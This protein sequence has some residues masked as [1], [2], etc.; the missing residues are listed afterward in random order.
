MT[1]QQLFPNTKEKYPSSLFHLANIKLP[2]YFDVLN[3]DWK[4]VEPMIEKE[5]LSKQRLRFAIFPNL[6]HFDFIHFC[7]VYALLIIYRK[8]LKAGEDITL[9]L[10][11]LLS[12]RSMLEKCATFSPGQFRCSGVAFTSEIS[13]A[14]KDR[15][16]QNVLSDLEGAL[17]YANEIDC[18]PVDVLFLKGTIGRFK[19]DISMVEEIIEIFKKGK[20]FNHS[21]WAYRKS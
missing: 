2:L 20:P 6:P 7:E 19:G 15:P 13:L 12:I 4:T 9:Y 8:K 3:G 17:A 1:M 21:S 10:N 5:M 11:G 18:I 14:L 16:L